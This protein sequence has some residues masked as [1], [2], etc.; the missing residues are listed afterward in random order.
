MSENKK[1]I[2]QT[3]TAPPVTRDFA[4]SPTKTPSGA[5]VWLFTAGGRVVN[6]TT[7]NSS[8]SIMDDALKIYSPALERLAKR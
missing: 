8:A 7:S 6:V 3:K 1:T 5:E 2:R 4:V